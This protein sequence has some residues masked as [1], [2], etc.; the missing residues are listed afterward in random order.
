LRVLANS[1]IEPENVKKKSW[2]TYQ[3]HFL[4]LDLQPVKEKKICERTEYS[5]GQF[6]LQIVHA[7]VKSKTNC[8]G[9]KIL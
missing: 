6:L 9:I 3:D 5:E 8:T 2:Y 7:L 1:D 4:S